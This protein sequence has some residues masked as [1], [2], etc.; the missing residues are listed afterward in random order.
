MASAQQR[1]PRDSALPV[2]DQAFSLQQLDVGLLHDHRCQFMIA[3]PAAFHDFVT[4][5]RQHRG[6]D[7]H[8]IKIVLFVI[9]DVMA[10]KPSASEGQ[11]YLLLQLS[12]CRVNMPFARIN[13]AAWQ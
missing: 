7:R 5:A 1:Q 10:Q 12:F 13:L 9:E 8:L 2:I 4:R 11:A 6:F 3:E